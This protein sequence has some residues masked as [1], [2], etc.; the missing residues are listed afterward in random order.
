M[1]GNGWDGLE[2]DVTR[3]GGGVKRYKIVFVVTLESWEGCENGKR[4]RT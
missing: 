3:D 4:K 1:L 2:L